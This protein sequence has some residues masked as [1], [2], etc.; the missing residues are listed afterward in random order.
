MKKRQPQSKKKRKAKPTLNGVTKLRVFDSRFTER[1]V[2]SKKDYS[3]KTKHK[4]S[5]FV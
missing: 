1:T 3:R 4:T 5:T 2:Q